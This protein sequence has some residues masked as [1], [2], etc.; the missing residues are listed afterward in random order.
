MHISTPSDRVIA[1]GA[2][3]GKEKWVKSRGSVNLVQPGL[4]V[5]HRC[6]QLVE[7]KAFSF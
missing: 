3:D 5:I 7:K 1:V 2:A 4:G 6:E